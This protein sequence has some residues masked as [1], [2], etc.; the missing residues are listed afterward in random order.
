MKERLM[1][2]AGFGSQAFHEDGG[3]HKWPTRRISEPGMH[4]RSTWTASQQTEEAH[5]QENL[6]QLLWEVTCK[7]CS[8]LFREGQWSALNQSSSD[9]S[10]LTTHPR[11]TMAYGKSL[12]REKENSGSSDSLCSIQPHK[13][14][15]KCWKNLIWVLGK[16][17]WQSWLNLVKKDISSSPIHGLPFLFRNLFILMNGHACCPRPEG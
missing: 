5:E 1:S 7:D 6:P 10:L 17:L 8:P 11:Y 14:R 9:S 15:E 12:S 3:S 4:L 2:N 16:K 13:T